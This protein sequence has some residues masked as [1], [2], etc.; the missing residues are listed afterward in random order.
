MDEYSLILS[1]Q[2]GEKEAFQN[3]IARYYPYVSKFLLKMCG[4]EGLSE[5]LTQDTFLKV[6]RGID[7]FQLEGKATFSTWVMT[8][9]K[10]C[11]L[12]YLRRTKHV[13]LSLDAQDEASPF[14]VQDAVLQCLQTDEVLKAL[15]NLP[16]EQATAIKL[17]YLEQQTLQ[18]IAD[19]VSCEPKTVKSRIHH[20]VTRLRKLLKGDPDHG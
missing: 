8:I 10:H 17:K 1:A 16:T 19:Q 13:L 20:G 5:D 9:A 4:D 2:K 3:L 6:I 7:R 15:E 18:E 11:Y 14:N 12:D